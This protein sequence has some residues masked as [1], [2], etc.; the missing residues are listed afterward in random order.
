MSEAQVIGLL[1][2]LWSLLWIWIFTGEISKLKEAKK[3]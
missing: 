3:K 1:L 2:F